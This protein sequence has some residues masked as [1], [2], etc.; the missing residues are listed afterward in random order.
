MYI[1]TKNW[2]YKVN[3]IQALQYY[4]AV[5]REV[6]GST[7][8][9]TV[10]NDTELII[11]EEDVLKEAETVEALCDY[12]FLF[13]EGHERPWPR[14]LVGYANVTEHLNNRLKYSRAK[15]IKLAILTDKGLIYVADYD[16]EGAK[17]IK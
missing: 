13:F 7:K 16:K 6:Y 5:K 15:K 9:Y 10:D 17:L 2:I 12:E 8:H 3:D 11:K 14:L 4:D 1:R